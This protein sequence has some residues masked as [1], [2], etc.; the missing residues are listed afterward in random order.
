MET[1]D[2]L[3]AVRERWNVLRHPF[4]QR[5][6]AG[7]LEHE[8]LGFYAGQYRHAVVALADQAQAA[9]QAAPP[10]LREELEGHAAEERD[11]VE[12]WDA[13]AEAFGGDTASAPL[14]E[15][16]GCAAAWTGGAGFAERLGVL[17]AVEASQPAISQTKLDGLA[18]HYGVARDH[19]ASAYFSLHSELDRAHGERAR[20]LIAEYASQAD[21]DAV[22][23]AAERALE[24]NWLLLDGVEAVGAPA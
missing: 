10:E 23:A 18:E 14:A 7:S 1:L 3:D 15:T 12:L 24:G 11:H 5:W 8:E 22:V 6:S 17:Y 19:G 16:A 20:K 2:R 13:F 21:A 9:A 4:Y